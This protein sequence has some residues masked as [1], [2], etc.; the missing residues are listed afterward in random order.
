MPNCPAAGKGP[1]RRRHRRH[2]RAA[3][4]VSSGAGAASG[5]ITAAIARV[6]VAVFSGSTIQVWPGQGIGGMQEREHDPDDMQA[7][8]LSALLVLADDFKETICMN[9]CYTSVRKAMA[10]DAEPRR[11]QATCGHQR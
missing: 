11:H 9:G 4:G 6:V 2:R 7:G 5:Q 3:L 10:A 1:R 8:L